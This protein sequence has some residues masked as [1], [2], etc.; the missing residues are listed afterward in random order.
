MKYARTM[1]VPDGAGVG[2]AV[3]A[4]V[5]DAVAAAADAVGAED[6]A[7]DALASAEGPGVASPEG[8]TTDALPVGAGE[9]GVPSGPLAGEQAATSARTVNR[10][11]VMATVRLVAR[12]AVASMRVPNALRIGPRRVEGIARR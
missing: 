10:M 11:T 4:G 3:G 5:G 2:E 6:G 7:I 1:V 12:M 9:D 8:G